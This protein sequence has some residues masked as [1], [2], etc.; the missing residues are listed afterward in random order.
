M[1]ATQSITCEANLSDHCA[2]TSYVFSGSDGSSEASTSSRKPRPG[3]VIATRTNGYQHSNP[4]ANG[5]ASANGKA[6]RGTAEASEDPDKREGERLCD[7]ICDEDELYKVLGV[8][9]R[10]K[11]E[12]IRRAFL[13]RSRLCHPE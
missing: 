4:Y 2:A 13:S 1:A 12:E 8:G 7:D 6:A 3:S 5:S 11:Q 9:K 10:A